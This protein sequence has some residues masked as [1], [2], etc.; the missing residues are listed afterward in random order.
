[1]DRIYAFNRP[2]QQLILQRHQGQFK[3][4]GLDLGLLE[5]PKLVFVEGNADKEKLGLPDAIYEE[6]SS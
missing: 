6:V 2:S 3:E 1:M 5:S 4:Q